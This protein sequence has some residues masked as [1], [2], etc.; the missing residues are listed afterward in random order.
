[1][2]NPLVELQHLGQSP[3]HDNISRDLLTSGKLAKMVAAGDITGL[4]SN[5][6]IFE[7][8]VARSKDY[9]DAIRVLAR[10]GKNA[11]D[12]FD[13]LAIEDIRAA[14]DVFA[15]VYARSGGAD[16]YASIE[17]APKF[18]TDTEAT[19]KEAHRLWKAVARPNLM[20]KI[21][22]TREG[23]P[24]I[25]R[26]IADGL[27]INVTLIFSLERYD[28][29]MDAYLAGLEKRLAARKPIARIASVASFF[30]SRV[31]TAVDA[32]LERKIAR[33]VPTSR[34][35]CGSSSAKRGSPTPSSL[36]PLSAGSSPARAGRL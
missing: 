20:V 7:H 18:A 19:I 26:C 28:E 10:K 36:T 2:A 15:P 30:V 32:Q 13:A 6:T 33:R 3:W 27:N 11:E 21:P 14:A 31:D 5:P 25:A 29:V 16:G 24:A 9:D 35:S 23:V 22:A 12:I 34:R 8:A 4:T 17:V 1:M